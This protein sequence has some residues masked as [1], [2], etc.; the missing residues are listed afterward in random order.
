MNALR[1]WSRAPV[2]VVSAS[3]FTIDLRAKKASRAGADLR[4]SPPPSGTSGRHNVGT[5]PGAATRPWSP[6]GIRT[7]HVRLSRVRLIHV[8]L[9]SCFLSG[10]TGEKYVTLTRRGSAVGRKDS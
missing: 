7:G 3:G 6:P 5:D 8:L 10:V 2:L 4:P 1:R 9:T